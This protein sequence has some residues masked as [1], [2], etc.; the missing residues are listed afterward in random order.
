[1]VLWVCR[2][3][4]LLGAAACK[5]DMLKARMGCS[6]PGMPEICVLFANCL[7]SGSFNLLGLLF[8]YYPCVDFVSYDS[9]IFEK[10]LRLLKLCYVMLF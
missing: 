4:W 6:L 8:F 2:G 7:I 9:A 10:V 3:W 1:M 5:V